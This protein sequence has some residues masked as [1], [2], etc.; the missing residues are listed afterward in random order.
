MVGSTQHVVSAELDFGA[1][2]TPG[3]RPRPER[4]P[5]ART[6]RIALAGGGTGGH[7]VPGLHLLALRRARASIAD[8]V[9]FQTGR[10][11]EERVLEGVEGRLLPARLE[12]VTLSL[13][14]DGGGAPS[15]FRLA[16]H[17]LPAVLRARRALARHRS[18]VLVGLG[19]FTS[20]PAVLAARSL[21][22]P[23]LLLEIN[24]HRGRATRWLAP[25]SA[26]VLHAW[27]ATL[28]AAS[29]GLPGDR[30]AWIGPPLSLELASGEPRPEET[31]RARSELGFD[32]DRPL[33]AILGGSQGAR[34]INAF[35]REHAAFW[36]LNGLQ[37]L[38]QVGP[39]RR[40]EGAG[41]AEG[42]RAVEYVHD[43][44]QLLR[45]S[46]LVLCRGGAS[47]LAEVGALRRPAWVVPYPHH[48]DR[49]QERN[50]RELGSGARIVQESELSLELAREILRICG[51]AGE[52]ERAA[53]TAALAGVVPLDGAARLFEAIEAL[54]SP[55]TSRFQSESPSS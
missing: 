42:Y 29:K 4:E 33:L 49:H 35:V 51:P 46:T 25:F 36:A 19:G 13:E 55:A 14:P 40:S 39:G 34:G 47:T 28:P 41:D 6:L 10:A 22:I 1:M 27:K 44:G 15:A 18:Q 52:A 5:A 50:A 24:A 16:S 8:V 3:A 21:G 48:A 38:H 9:W 54:A 30:D 23:V 26:R 53:M 2:N 45:A 7:I 12:R 31:R 32:A 20:L 43:V 37:V 11:V 17:T